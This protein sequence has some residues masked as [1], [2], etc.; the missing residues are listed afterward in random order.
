MTFVFLAAVTLLF[1]CVQKIARPYILLAASL[2][3]VFYLDRTACVALIASS[4]VVY[5][6]GA[7]DY[8]LK[9]SGK[10]KTAEAVTL[11]GMILLVLFW[12]IFKIVPRLSMALGSGDVTHN[13]L[14]K[15][16]ILPIGYSYYMFQG[17]SYLS[18][19]HKDKIIP[20]KNVFYFMLYMCFFPK[21]ISGPI[22]R[23]DVFLNHIKK[24]SDVR[25]FDE[26][27]LSSAL[28]YCLYGYFMKIVVAD[29]LGLYVG[30][31]FNDYH[32][33]CPF[34]LVV[35]A[36]LYSMQIYCDFAGYSALAVGVSRL[37]GIEL[38]QNFLAP[39]MAVDIS[40]FWRRWHRSLSMWLKDYIYIPLGGN[41]KGKVRQ[42]LNSM[43]VF[44]IC[45]IW[46]G[47]GL[48]FLAWGFIHGIYTVTH[49]LM[50]E[51]K[52]R[53]N[54]NW[55]TLILKRTATFFLAT[56]A[57]IFFGSSGLKSAIG[58]IERMIL[59]WGSDGAKLAE[60]G[61]DLTYFL[62]FAICFLAIFLMDMQV[63]KKR[64]AFPDV[65]MQWHYVPRYIVYLIFILTIFVFGM[66]GPGYDTGQFM[67]MSF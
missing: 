64:I 42:Y 55:M 31:I 16:I 13:N 1:F 33:Y 9:R 46:H 21:F 8:N 40:D 60:V 5:A 28:G 6:V 54:N 22:E 35:G 37:Y 47:N 49:S 19:I 66:Y 2:I 24:L 20:E 63:S 27:R 61:L 3:Y 4:S 50:K 26:E 18:D 17:I 51:K 25:L 41:R 48:N 14:L 10:E 44:L 7:Y 12:S 38:T 62:F 45:G 65:I 23:A 58:Y 39:Y 52:S 67:Y 53:L 56:F 43:I 57:W 29:R 36:L 30:P 11:F 34:V 59:G 32:K 15:N